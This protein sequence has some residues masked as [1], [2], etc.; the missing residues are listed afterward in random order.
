[1]VSLPHRNMNVW[2][3]Q[4]CINA[5]TT[6]M[7]LYQHLCNVDPMHCVGWEHGLV[8]CPHAVL[9][10]PIPFSS[11][12]GYGTLNVTN[13]LY[14]WPVTVELYA[15]CDDCMPLYATCNDYMPLYATCNDFAPV[16]AKRNF[17]MSI[18]ATRGSC[19]SLNSTCIACMPLDAANC[20]ISR[21]I[22]TPVCL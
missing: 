2:L 4:R 20:L 1:M 7:T 18:Y 13:S 17:F 12:S 11:D 5:G 22:T 8:I 9:V 14:Y 15:T 3:D 16:Y 10:S 19:M 6:S 21:N